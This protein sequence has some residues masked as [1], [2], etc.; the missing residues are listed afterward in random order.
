MMKTQQPPSVGTN[1]RVLTTTNSQVSRLQNY[2]IQYTKQK[3]DLVEKKKKEEE[4]KK[5]KPFKARPLPKFIKSQKPGSADDADGNTDDA[6]Q[7]R[8]SSAPNTR[9]SSQPRTLAPQPAKPVYRTRSVSAAA[10]VAAV[11]RFKAKPAPVTTT[12]SAPPVARVKPNIKASA[13]KPVVPA[14]R[15]NDKPS[16]APVVPATGVNNQKKFVAKVPSYLKKEPFKVKL[17]EKKAAVESKPFNLAMTGRLEARQKMDNE[18]RKAIEEKARQELDEKRKREDAEVKAMRKQRE[19]KA[20]TNPFGG[21][22][23]KKQAIDNGAS[24]QA[25]AGDTQT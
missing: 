10:A 21:K 25:P 17:P 7:H 12:K 8:P 16:T 18:R 1:G 19:F 3:Q 11:P 24:E 22:V 4:Q 15:K 13:P 9:A 23:T 5:P 20:R 2:A 6:Q 14:T